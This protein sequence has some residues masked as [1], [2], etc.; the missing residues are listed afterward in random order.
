MIV[1][2]LLVESEITSTGPTV[3]EGTHTERITNY[4]PAEQAV[5]TLF[6]EID[7]TVWYLVALNSTG[8][9]NTWIYAGGTCRTTLANIIT[10][11]GTNDT[12]FL[13]FITD[14]SHLLYWTGSAW[15]WAPADDG[16]GYYRLCE[17]APAGFGASAW[18]ICDGTGPIPRLNADGTTT[19]VTVPNLATAAYLKGGTS[20]AAVAAAGGLT[21]SVSGGTPAGTVSAP[22]FTGTPGTTGTNSTNQ[23]VQVGLG[24]T[25]A[26]DGHTHSITPAGTNS[27]PTFTGS[28]LAGHDHGPNTLELRNK[29]G[30]LYYRR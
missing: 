6:Y 25:V 22:T 8:S 24:V 21:T 29:Q 3:I 20:A 10:S 23:E 12:G 18:Q 11:L 2:Q 7:R 26:A 13:N 15:T 1:D 9:V 17:T 27:A 16:S 14:Y 5:G 4:P 19:N 28:A 30:I